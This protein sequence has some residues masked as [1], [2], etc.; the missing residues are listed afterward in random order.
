MVLCNIVG[1]SISTPTRTATPT[2]SKREERGIQES[3]VNTQ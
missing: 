2:K 3:T 1:A